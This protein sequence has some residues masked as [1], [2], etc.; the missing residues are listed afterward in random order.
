MT[1][2]MTKP[3]MIPVSRG[4][5]INADLAWPEMKALANFLDLAETIKG[6]E[7]GTNAEADLITQ[8]ADGADLG[9]MW[10]EYQRLIALHNRERSPMVNLLSYQTSRVVE[11]V[12][13]PIAEDFEE[14]SEFGEPKGIRLGA[15][16]MMGFDFKWWDIAIRYT[17]RW[18]AENTRAEADALTNAAIEA[19][20][21]LQFVKIL[22]RLFNNVANTTTVNDT[23]INVYP[24]YNGDSMVPP[25]YKSTTHTA[26]HTHY[27]ASGGATIDSGDIDDIQAHLE[28]HGY[29]LNRGYRMILVVNQVEANVIRTFTVAGGDKYDFIPSAGF[30]G[31]IMAPGTIIGRPSEAV[32]GMLTVGTYGPWTVVQEDYMPAGYVLGFVSGGED[33]IGNL[34]GV[35]EH[36]NA[37]LRGLRLLRGSQ[38]DYPLVDSFYQRAFGTG[39]RHRGAGVVMQITAG[40]YT[41]PAEYA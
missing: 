6:S 41:V 2:T 17:W 29:V 5:E 1:D 24:L 15:P 3:T 20:N 9:P 8:T 25:K 34:I 22:R 31:I 32:P 10:R 38:H 26:P 39:V 37:A 36:E 13:Y 23:A 27:L 11:K 12:M 14:A 7:R 35:R 4:L 40:A 18:L 21:R 19:D 16:F 30:G 33:N 28:H